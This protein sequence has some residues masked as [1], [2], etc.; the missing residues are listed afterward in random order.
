MIYV[1]PENPVFPWFPNTPGHAI[2]MNFTL[3]FSRG[4]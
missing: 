2:S 3:I 4:F 1:V